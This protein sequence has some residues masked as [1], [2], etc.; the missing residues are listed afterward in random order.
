MAAADGN[1]DVEDDDSDAVKDEDN[2]A[3]DVR[4][5]MDW[6]RVRAAL[7]EDEGVASSGADE[8]MS[9]PEEIAV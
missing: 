6:C 7:D 4:E 2:D 1:T 8:V 9:D 3:M 5:S